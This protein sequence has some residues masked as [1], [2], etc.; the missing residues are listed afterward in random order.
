MKLID[1]KSYLSVQLFRQVPKVIEEGESPIHLTLIGMLYQIISN[2]EFDSIKTD[3]SKVTPKKL[4]EIVERVELELRNDKIQ[5][6]NSIYQD[7]LNETDT[8][9]LEAYLERKLYWQFA[10]MVDIG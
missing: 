6:I 8:S 4:D 10:D 9:F 3:I 5:E 1:I 2:Y 7:I